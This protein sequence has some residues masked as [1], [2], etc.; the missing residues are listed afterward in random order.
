MSG[1]QL[2]EFIDGYINLSSHVLDCLH[3]SDVLARYVR[4]S[5]I[6]KPLPPRPSL[7]ARTRPSSGPGIGSILRVR[8]GG[9]SGFV[10][11]CVDQ[12]HDRGVFSSDAG[13]CRRAVWLIL[14]GTKAAVPF[15]DYVAPSR[16]ARACACVRVPMYARGVVICSVRYV[17]SV[18]AVRD[19]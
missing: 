16:R 11:P 8:C 10:V 1:D 15:A 5:L 7:V 19:E 4:R 6:K 3:R 12:F 9:C 13:A 18:E 2:N 14:A 17:L